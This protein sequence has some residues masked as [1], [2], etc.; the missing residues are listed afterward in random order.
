MVEEKTYISPR[1]TV[2]YWLKRKAGSEKICLV[3][4]HGLLANHTLFE[5][6]TAYFS[7]FH[8]VLAWDAPAHGKS[9]PYTPFSCAGAAEDLKE[10]LDLEGLESCVLLGQSMGGFICQSFLLRWPDRVSGFVGIGTCP[11]GEGYYSA[12]DRWW[13]R[14]VGW[15]ARLYPDGVLRRSVAKNA[16]K[17]SHAYENMLCSMAVY[18]KGELCRLMGI[19]MAGML[20]E[21]QNLEISCPVLIMI[22]EGDCAGKVRQYNRKWH[23]RTGFPI[24]VVKGAG[25]NANLD[26]WEDVNGR[27]EQFLLDNGI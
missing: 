1:G 18:P 25:H 2:H 26:Q 11:Y 22:G 27:I 5:K 4:L 19:G 23:E 16:T 10:I 9:R 8:T 20:E 15:M 3:F 7:L 21:N 24:Y 14:Q 12:L 6:Q 13:L 17:T